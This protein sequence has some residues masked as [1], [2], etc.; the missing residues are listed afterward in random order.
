MNL[1]VLVERCLEADELSQKNNLPSIHP[2]TLRLDEI[3]EILSNELPKAGVT[4]LASITGFSDLPWPVWISI[5][6]NAKA[7][8]QSS[9][10]SLSH[11]SALIGSAMEGIELSKAEEYVPT[12]QIDSTYND[13]KRQN[14]LDLAKSPIPTDLFS[15]TT[16]ISWTPSKKL[17]KNGLN[18]KKGCLIPVNL[19]KLDFRKQELDPGFANTSNGLAS[20]FK[21]EEAISQALL[22]CV[23]RHSST[24]AN[25]YGLT[26]QVDISSL[27][28]RCN[29]M[30]AELID[31]GF[32]ATISD[33]TA[34]KGL[35]VFECALTPTNP[36]A[37]FTGGLGWGC[38]PNPEIAL[39]R[40]ILEANQ[41]RTIIISGS[42]DDMHKNIYL[43]ERVRQRTEA[44]TR[45]IH[46]SRPE[47][48]IKFSRKEP[49]LAIADYISNT[50]DILASYGFEDIYVVPL[51]SSK[52]PVQVVKVIVP[53]LEGYHSAT[54]KPISSLNYRNGPFLMASRLNQHSNMGA[55]KL[56]AG[57]LAQ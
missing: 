45:I 30:I 57:G 56:N 16:S 43:R 22:E 10:K 37:K 13:A 29:H 18:S 4:R 53:G 8:S 14:C 55:I 31:L 15:S 51:T 6:P 47:S 5:R 2:N 27:P 12:T 3:T 26:K 41:A 28:E 9:G 1:K 50:M 33:C 19:I 32:L 34:F 49:P 24:L 54:Y 40:S 52:E 11:L 39:L 44:Y 48:E 7:L 38:H 35:P 17:E 42:R 25:M 46:Q 20:G 36:T 23:E 21:R